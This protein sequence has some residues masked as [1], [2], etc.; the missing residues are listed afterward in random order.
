MPWTHRPVS[1]TTGHTP[2]LPADP[3]WTRVQRPS[4][5]A[6]WPSREGDT[7]WSPQG[8]D[9]GSATQATWPSPIGPSPSQNPPHLL[10]KEGRETLLSGRY[11]NAHTQERA[12]PC[13]WLA[14]RSPWTKPLPGIFPSFLSALFFGSFTEAHLCIRR[15]FWPPCVRAGPRNEASAGTALPC[16]AFVS[17]SSH[18]TP[19]PHPSPASSPGAQPPGRGTHGTSPLSLHL[20]QSFL[21]SLT[22]RTVRRTLLFSEDMLFSQERV[23]IAKKD[24]F[25]DDADRGEGEA[26]RGEGT[27][28]HRWAVT[29]QPRGWEVQHRKHSDL[30]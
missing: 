21:F 1:I 4:L 14:N 23:N 26:G 24:T 10:S 5:E 19:T 25:R 13:S 18:P 28:D 17:A 20:L 29:E 7:L 30:Y 16:V 15:C 27:E 6:A 2:A 12:V 22:G 11:L 3:T 9:K 8:S